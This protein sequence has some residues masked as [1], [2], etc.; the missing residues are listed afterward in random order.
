MSKHR[1]TKFCLFSKPLLP[2]KLC[3]QP[4]FQPLFS[5]PVH[6]MSCNINLHFL[7]V[8]HH[9]PRLPLFPQVIWPPQHYP[10]FLSVSLLNCFGFVRI[11]LV[12]WNLMRPQK[13]FTLYR[14][15]D[16]RRFLINLNIL[17]VHLLWVVQSSE[18]QPDHVQT[19]FENV[20]IKRP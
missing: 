5:K 15:P 16:S 18:M 17:W 9:L 3:F 14:V 1:K 13:S 12:W 11:S 4:L 19:R 10:H 2:G 7:P 6:K 8:L 20:L